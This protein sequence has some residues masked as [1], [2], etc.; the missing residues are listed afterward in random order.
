MKITAKY[1]TAKPILF[2]GAAILIALLVLCLLPHFIK[3]NANL[4]PPQ[5]DVSI[6]SAFNGD[7]AGLKD[8]EIVPTL[9]TPASP[10]KNVIWCASFLSSWK[11]MEQNL[12][13]EPIALD[14]ASEVAG[15]LNSAADPS[16]AI[17]VAALYTVTGGN[18][19]GLMDQIQTDFQPRFPGKQPPKFPDIEPNSFVAYSY[20]EASIKFPLPYN[21]N[22]KPF[23]FTDGS[24]KQTEIKSFGIPVENRNTFYAL[25]AQPR[26]LFRGESVENGAQ[27]TYAEFVIDL[28][29]NSSPNQIIVSKMSAETNLAAAVAHVENEIRSTPFTEVRGLSPDDSLLVPDFNWFI[30]HHFS[31]FEGKTF[32]N[33]KLKGQRIDVAQQDISFRLDKNGAGLQAESELNATSAAQDYCLDGPFL[34][35]MKKRGA[36]M[37]YF[38]MWVDNAE[39]LSPWH[40]ATGETQNPPDHPPK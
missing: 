11:A 28:C 33:G 26:I 24:G 32:A 2:L 30:S 7:S 20:L 31:A 19:N 39:L 18:K 9:E 35:Y 37:P 21:Q 4:P 17:P 1:S 5:P 25:R 27:F 36:Q 15:L 40:P 8:T 16:P 3:N 13:G 34:I 12:A 29:S 38:V 14:G 10:G 23:V 6:P 22:E